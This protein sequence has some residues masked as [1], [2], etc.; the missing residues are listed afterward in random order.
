MTRLIEILISLAIVAVLFLVVGLV[1]P[2]KRHISEKVETNRKMTIVFDTLNSFRRFKDW[3]PLL[4]RDPRM[5]LKTSGPDAGVGARLDYTSKKPELGSGSLEITASEPGKHIAYAVE[6]NKMG[7]DKRT[8]FVFKPTGRSGRNVEITE[9]YDV[10]YGWNLIGRYAGLY[11]RSHVGDDMKL[12]L[13]KLTNMLAAVPNVDY[14]VKGSKLAG[15]QIVERPAEHL[16]VVSAGSVERNNDI[17]KASMRA[18]MEWIKRT[19]DASGLTPVGPM[20]IV[21]TEMGRESYTFDVV[22]PVRK[23][24]ATE[25]AAADAPLTGLSLQGPVKYEQT[26]S[27]RAATATYSGFMAE[28]DNVRNALRA[29]AVTHGYE[30]TERPYETYNNGIDQ[31]FTET[32]SYNVYWAIK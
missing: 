19:M 24:T 16:L 31:A 9:T 15:L 26:K 20:R 22:Q 10:D 21:T 30:V 4:L 5:E 6:N 28:L 32:G 2:S 27:G 7:S 29:W 8:E 17:V 14:A 11:V 25:G 13:T 12:G 3:N 23:A 18:N 1:L